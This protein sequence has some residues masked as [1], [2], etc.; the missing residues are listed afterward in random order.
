MSLQTQ[1]AP[2]YRAPE[3]DLHKDRLRRFISGKRFTRN[4]RH[5]F[6]ATISVIDWAGN[7]ELMVL[8]VPLPAGGATFTL[9]CATIAFKFA[10][11]KRNTCAVP[12]ELEKFSS[13]NVDV[14]GP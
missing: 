2:R 10:L 3:S 12:L 7:V 5:Y 9:G 4:G 11:L 8:V 13:D 6:G 1:L 14:S